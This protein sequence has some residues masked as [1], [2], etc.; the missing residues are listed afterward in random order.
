MRFSPIASGAAALAIATAGCASAGA[1]GPGS[2][3]GAATLVPANAVAFVAARSDLSASRWHGLGKLALKQLPGWGADLQAVARDEIDLAVLPGEKTVVFLQPSDRA[4]LAALAKKH[5]LVQRATGGWTAV[6]A[7]EAA[8]AAVASATSHL[9]TDARFV[10]AMNRLPGDALMRAYARGA[11]MSR[12][13]EAIPGQLQTRALP[14]RAKFRLQRDKKGAPTYGLARQEFR[15]LAV[16]LSSSGDGLKLQGFAPSAGLAAAGPPRFAAV[17]VAPYAAALV[18]EIPSGALAVVDFQV[19]RGGFELMPKLPVQLGRLLGPDLRDLP[20]ELDTVLG[21]E[22][23][24]YVRA[25]LPVPEITLVTQPA[26]TTAASTT[27]DELLASLPKG[28]PLE[29]FPLHRAV[30]GG[31]LVVSTTQRGIDDF[32]SGGPKLS[33]DPAFLEAKKQSGMPDETTG[34]AYANA[35]DALPLLALAGVTLPA[36]LPELGTVAVF[37]AVFGGGTATGSTFTAYVGLPSS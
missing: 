20:N 35:R 19:P 12:L 36:G 1:S 11:E 10:A 32:R 25:G 27:L 23:A 3:D 33:A 15:W 30:I 22:S 16:A 18:D 28:S 29:R 7:S 8:L 26:D 14:P 2:L 17:P 4:K 5:H 34:F 9:A 24:V 6:A 37:G 13:L 31:Q 21:G